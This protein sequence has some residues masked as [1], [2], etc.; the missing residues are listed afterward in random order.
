[1]EILRVS[2]GRKLSG[3][4]EIQGAKNSVLPIMA[5][6]MLTNGETVIHNCPRLRDV[7]VSINILKH[8]GRK[9]RREG[10]DVI[11][12]SSVITCNE[13]P[14][15]LM[16]EMRSSVVFLG[17]ILAMN[18]AAELSAPGGCELGPRPIDLHIDAIR[19]FGGEVE[20]FGG[21]LSVR[22]VKSWNTRSVRNISFPI[23]SVGATENAMLLAARTPGRTNIINAAREPEI[24]D[25]SDFLN[26]IGTVCTGAGTGMI[27]IDY[28]PGPSD[29]ASL[30]HTIIPDRIVTATYLAAV[31]SA[32]GSAELKGSIADD[33]LPVISA[34]REMGCEITSSDLGTTIFSPA[35][36]KAC[37]PIST[38][39]Y[40]GFPTDAQ[41]PLLAASLKAEGTTVFVENIFENRYRHIEELLRLG[42]DA[43]VEGKTAFVHGVQRLRGANTVAPDL[44]GG[45]ALVVASLGAIGTSEISGTKH[46]KRGY[47]RIDY[48]LSMLN[49]D[50]TYLDQ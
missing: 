35:R 2:G 46:I 33:L 43:S 45:A 4:I 7:E 27:T 50:V 6:A 17:A 48:F 44:R 15:S 47:E 8:L 42:A 12:A 24:R 11:I 16:R 20:N 23:T 5:A 13:I 21:K 18:K 41:P 10:R 29:N 19:E 32:G 40:P 26:K 34:L 36:L 38:K 22:M 28:S 37:K 30:E 49:A 9:V 3:S 25:L 1:M 14:D 31:A 39:P